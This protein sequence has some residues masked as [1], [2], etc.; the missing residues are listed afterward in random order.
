M[1]SYTVKENLIGLAVT[2]ILWYR[3]TDAV[4]FI[5]LHIVVICYSNSRFSL[6]MV[7]GYFS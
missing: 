1:R 3:D 7:L 2:E 6:V 5:R 4:T